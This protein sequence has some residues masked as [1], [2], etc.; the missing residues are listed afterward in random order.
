MQRLSEL[1][2][3]S[4]DR[5][6]RQPRLTCPPANKGIQLNFIVARLAGISSICQR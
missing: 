2:P 1:A 6:K 4:T 3:G 5:K